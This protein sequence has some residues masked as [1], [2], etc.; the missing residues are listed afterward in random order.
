MGVREPIS[1]TNDH[2]LRRIHFIVLTPNLSF[3]CSSDFFGPDDVTVRAKSKPIVGQRL[4]CFR[5]VRR[6]RGARRCRS[7]AATRLGHY[8]L[9]PLLCPLDSRPFVI[10]IFGPC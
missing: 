9:Y 5:W 10:I 7:T 8:L 6:C 1:S 3:L 4:I 2:R